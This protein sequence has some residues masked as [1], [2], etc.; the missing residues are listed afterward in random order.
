M[1]SHGDFNANYYFIKGGDGL[2]FPR[3]VFVTAIFAAVAVESL[4][5]FVG[6]RWF[7]RHIPLLVVRWFR[8][9]NPLLLHTS[10]STTGTIDG[11][12][13][14]KG[15]RIVVNKRANG[16]WHGTHQLIVNSNSQCCR[17]CF[18]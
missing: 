13:D 5:Q 7:R 4:H 18:Q 12:I 9:H 15:I 10:A 14:L 8:R 16:D 2:V 11:A 17:V 1:M 3:Q 6:V